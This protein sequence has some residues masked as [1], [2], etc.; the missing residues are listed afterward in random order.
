M[1]NI[2]F[3]L[4]QYFHPECFMCDVCKNKIQKLPL[5][6]EVR[7]EFSL[8]LSFIALFMM[9]EIVSQMGT[10]EPEGL[11]C[12]ECYQKKKRGAIMSQVKK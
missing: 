5:E 12:R 9:I 3:E 11:M 4:D 1:N 7:C 2:I 10:K 8:F 6:W